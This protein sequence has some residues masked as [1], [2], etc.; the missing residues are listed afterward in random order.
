MSFKLLP[1]LS[2]EWNFKQGIP[3]FELLVRASISKSHEDGFLGEGTC[4][5][6]CVLTGGLFAA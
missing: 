3:I 5:R 4:I 2:T 1:N 6:V